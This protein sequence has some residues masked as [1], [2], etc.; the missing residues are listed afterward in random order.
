M[1]TVQVLDFPFDASMTDLDS[2]HVLYTPT[3]GQILLDGY[4]EIDEAFDGSPKGDIGT[5]DAQI[6]GWIAGV[7]AQSVDMRWKDN[8]GQGTG[9]L[10]GGNYTNMSI[11]QG[12]GTTERIVPGKLI[13]GI[14]IKVV[15]SV[16]GN[17]NGGNSGCTRGSGTVYLV[18]AS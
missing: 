6:D 15:V 7:T 12:Q 13:G 17:I 1:R 10:T 14:P 3:D 4:I 16:N 9:L 11:A 5:F 8:Q 18:I 2:G